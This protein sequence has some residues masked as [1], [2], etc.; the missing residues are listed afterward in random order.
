MEKEILEATIAFKI[1]PANNA[2]SRPPY[3]ASCIAA[4]FEMFGALIKSVAIDKPGGG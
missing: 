2:C 4:R 1:S 3:R